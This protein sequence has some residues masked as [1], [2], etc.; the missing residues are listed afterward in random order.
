[1]DRWYGPA[2]GLRRNWRDLVA[3]TI[4]VVAL[5]GSVAL[6]GDGRVAIGLELREGTSEEDGRP[7][8]FVTTVVPD[9]NAARY[10]FGVGQRVLELTTI[11]GGKVPQG[12]PEFISADGEL[13]GVPV[14]AVSAE[15]IER[16]IVGEVY[17][18]G[19]A[20]AV[21]YGYGWR[22]RGWLES[23]LQSDI[24][25]VVFG[26]L[27]GLVVGYLLYRGQLGAAG[28]DLAIVAG[29]AVALPLLLIPV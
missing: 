3:L 23:H 11:D 19:H 16:V 28:R 25:A 24:Y 4:A 12:S 21:V 27:L 18:D 13:V 26:S 15:R 17:D 7:G 5:V 29:S 1:M 14:E 20:A 9:G 8:V 22:E 2:M 6:W 10:G